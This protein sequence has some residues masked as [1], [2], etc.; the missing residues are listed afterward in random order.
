MQTDC[1]EQFFSSF[2][3]LHARTS[4][5]NLAQGQGREVWERQVCVQRPVVPE[6]NL[7][8]YQTSGDE[9]SAAKN[10][11]TK[12]PVHLCLSRYF[13]HTWVS[14][15]ESKIRFSAHHAS[16]SGCKQPHLRWVSN[17]SSPAFRSTMRKHF[18]FG[19][20]IPDSSFPD[21]LSTDK[22]SL[23]TGCGATFETTLDDWYAACAMIH[24]VEWFVLKTKVPFISHGRLSLRI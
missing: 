22:W 6:S 16:L 12:L 4:L 7:S 9:L 15:V 24:S 14:F 21:I 18:F 23:C 5:P 3:F 2:Y 8:I 13:F 11:R 20:L 1:P 19:F 17:N 10:V